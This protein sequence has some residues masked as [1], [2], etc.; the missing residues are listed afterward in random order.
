MY[1]TLKRPDFGI[2]ISFQGRLVC[3]KARKSG[4]NGP[5]KK[6]KQQNDMF[7]STGLS[8]FSAQVS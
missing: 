7:K 8:N 1:V 2:P 5:K 4:C 3:E 6:E